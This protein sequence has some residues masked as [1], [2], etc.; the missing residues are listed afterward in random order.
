MSALPTHTSC[1]PTNCQSLLGAQSNGSHFRQSLRNL[2]SFQAP[3]CG[4][5]PNPR[6]FVTRASSSSCLWIHGNHMRLNCSLERNVRGNLG[7]GWGLHLR[8]LLCLLLTTDSGTRNTLSPC[9]LTVLWRR[10]DRKA[11]VVWENNKKEA[12][13]KNCQSVTAPTEPCATCSKG[14]WCASRAEDTHRNMPVA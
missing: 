10:N 4:R 8:L 2:Q 13:G 9:L 14:A 12:W 11:S 1:N 3:L 6:P 5:L 7:S